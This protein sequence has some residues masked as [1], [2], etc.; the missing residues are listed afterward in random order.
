ME[1]I[2]DIIYHILFIIICICASWSFG[3][4]IAI[5][6]TLKEINSKQLKLIKL[7][8]E[9]NNNYKEAINY[10]EKIIKNY[11]IFIKQNMIRRKTPIIDE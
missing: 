5:N 2:L 1:T 3:S 4:C 11:L 9:E 10:Y 8:E 7:L 6:K